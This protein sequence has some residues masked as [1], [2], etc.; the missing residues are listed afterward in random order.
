MVRVT[1]T[2]SHSDGHKMVK[3]YPI[4]KEV[5]I[6]NLLRDKMTLDQQIEDAQKRLDKI[7]ELLDGVMHLK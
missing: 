7:T 4:K 1:E 5:Y 6:Q 2:E 3:E